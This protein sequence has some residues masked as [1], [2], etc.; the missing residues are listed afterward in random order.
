LIVRFSLTRHTTPHH[1]TPTPHLTPQGTVYEINHKSQTVVQIQVSF[2]GLLMS[3]EG[4]KT[5]L[6]GVGGAL[7]FELDSKIYILIKKN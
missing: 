1:N 3:L 6:L 7:K 4:D 2:G 5:T